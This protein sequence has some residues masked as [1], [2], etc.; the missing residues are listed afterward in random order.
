M[1]L[2]KKIATFFLFCTVILVGGNIGTSNVKAAELKTPT[3]QNATV[4]PMNGITQYYRSYCFN[5]NGAACS[6]AYYDKYY[7][8]DAFSVIWSASGSWKG[9]VLTDRTGPNS[10][11]NCTGVVLSQTAGPINVDFTTSY[12]QLAYG[13]NNNS[14]FVRGVQQALMWLGYNIGSAGV[15][16][17]YG[18]NTQNAVIAFQR[19]HG[20]TADGVVGKNT[21]WVL[22]QASY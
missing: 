8:T 21:Y 11:S 4:Q 13:E 20:L 15:D 2:L 16:G 1:K 17:D 18:L 9:Y 6:P 12:Y 22:S 10:V 5:Q 19:N 3:V 14:S 7:K